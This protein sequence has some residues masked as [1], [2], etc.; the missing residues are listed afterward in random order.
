MSARSLAPRKVLLPGCVGYCFTNVSSGET[1]LMVVDKAKGFA[2]LL[3]K[4]PMVGGNAI[5]RTYFHGS[6]MKASIK[7]A[8]A[9]EK[10]RY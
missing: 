2:V 6:D 3:S 7:R 4:L 5:E 8:E 1:I 9:A 10:S